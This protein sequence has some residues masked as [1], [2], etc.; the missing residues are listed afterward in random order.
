[1]IAFNIPCPIEMIS[2][3]ILVHCSYRCILWFQIGIKSDDYHDHCIGRIQKFEKGEVYMLGSRATMQWGSVTL[4]V[5]KMI[6][7]SLHLA[8]WFNLTRWW[9]SRNRLSC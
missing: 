7:S 6:A 4:L 9:W 2:C 8:Q 5:N 3:L 1:M